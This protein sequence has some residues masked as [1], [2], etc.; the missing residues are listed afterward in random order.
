MKNSTL[1]SLL[2]ILL[3]ACAAPVASPTA[4][5]TALPSAS[6][7]PSATATET[8]TPSPTGTP[9]APPLPSIT[10]VTSYK[11]MKAHPEALP[12]GRTP[13][14]RTLLSESIRQ[15]FERRE[16]P[17]FDES[18]P[19]ISDV[20]TFVVNHNMPVY[21]NY[22]NVADASSWAT[23]H[24]PP[25]RGVT[26]VDGGNG[27]IYAVQAVKQ[28]DSNVPGLIWYMTTPKNINNEIGVLFGDLEGGT[29]LPRK[30]KSPGCVEKSGEI[31][32]VFLDPQIISAQE[33]AITLFQQTGN[34]PKEMS[35]GAIVFLMSRQ[36]LY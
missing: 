12:R 7:L 9:T 5:V 33:S 8:M 20:V 1:I 11:E 27:T 19:N 32:L 26:L 13:G 2:I 36:T 25:M 15:M 10:L 24:N 4:T 22:F 18:I 6:P 21:E 16:I 29:V 3:T 34:I 17:N 30:I 35:N 23:Q 31:C 14:E 28:R